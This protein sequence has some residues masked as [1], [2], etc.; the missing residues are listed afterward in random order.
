VRVE[1]FTPV[2]FGTRQV[3]NFTT[4]SYPQLG[5]LLFGLFLIGVAGVLIWH[6]VRGR[7]QAL[8]SL[9]AVPR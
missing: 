5:T 3:A 8:A 1:P 9:T 2:I 7:R 6:L 4:S